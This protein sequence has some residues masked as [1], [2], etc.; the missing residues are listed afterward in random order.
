MKIKNIIFD[1]GGVLYEINHTES[2]NK[3][4]ELSSEPALFSPENLKSFQK[5]E[6]LTGYE[7]GR[8]SSKEFRHIL[9]KQFKI[10]ASDEIFDEA[11]NATL[12]SLYP[13]SLEIVKSYKKIGKIFLLSNTSEIHYKK[14]EPECR[15]LFSLFEKCFFSFQ[16]GVIKPNPEIYKKV[17]ST[18]AINP[19]ETLF[20]DDTEANLPPAKNAGMKVIH[21]QNRRQLYDLLNHINVENN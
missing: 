16:L 3:F 12:V 15:N 2:L 14:F 1:F 17:I 21:L 9:K 4:S 7:S 10:K 18:A 8:I 5:N 11:W 19:G 20:I 6:Y 13:D